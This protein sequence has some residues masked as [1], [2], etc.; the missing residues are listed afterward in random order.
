MKYKINRNV[1]R[2][3]MI[4][5]NNIVTEVNAGFLKLT[6]YSENE[7]INKTIVEVGRIL[8]I[9]SQINLQ[10]LECNGEFYIFH[11]SLQ[12][13][14][15]TIS[16]IVKFNEKILYF[17]KNIYFNIEEKFNFVEQIY[18]D[19]EPSILIRSVP[20]SILLKSNQNYLNMLKEP[21][22]SIENSIGK[23]HKEIITEYENSESQNPWDKLINNLKHC[24][25]EKICY[26]HY[27][28]GV[29][30]LNVSTMPIFVQGKLKY[31]IQVISDVTEK[32]QNSKAVEQ[33]NQELEAII[34]NVSDGLFVVDKNLNYHLYNSNSREFLYRVNSTKNNCDV[35]SRTKPNNFESS[36]LGKN[37]CPITRVL[38]GE[39]IR[40]YRFMCNSSGQIFHYNLGGSP[41]YDKNGNVEKAI[42]CTHDITER[43]KSEENLLI[44]TQYD[45]LRNIIENLEI[46]YLRC[47]YPEFKIIHLNNKAYYD[48]KKTNSTIVSLSSIE[49]RYVNDVSIINKDD[50]NIIMENQADKNHIIKKMVISGEEKYF[51]ILHHPLYGVNNQIIEIII[52]TIDITKEIKEKNEIE[53][54]IK[55]QEELF[56]NISHELKTPLN[57]IFSANQLMELYLRNNLIESNLETISRNN[58]M[59]KQNC[60]RLIKL[61]NN[62]V[63]LSKFESGFYKLHTS[64]RNIVR[65]VENI[66]K[67]VSD[68]INAVGLNVIFDSD[69][70]EKIIAIDVEKIERVILNLL[71]NAI[72][73]S[74][75]GNGIFVNVKDLGEFVEISVKDNG[76]GID[77]QHLPYIFDRFYQVDKSLTRDS[78]GSGIG[79]ALIKSIVEFHSGKISV[80]SEVDRG[81]TFKIKL[82]AIVAE[83][84]FI[85]NS[86]C[87]SDKIELINIEFSDIYQI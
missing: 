10:S 38:K 17:K 70:E 67:S 29:M 68:Y 72:K 57:V 65:V 82:P 42:I 76:I 48:L 45:L 50:L 21:Y 4:I 23:K 51:K 75:P 18:I 31:V 32:I 15:V 33:R 26:N 47:S 78:E 20:D 35:L 34:D 11:K 3:F 71:S 46:G 22:N 83:E 62:I 77:K 6:G 14:E 61:I 19:R 73:F 36:S 64:N 12:V 84:K 79:L 59:I 28:R 25:T 39:R 30:Y 9:D 66:V 2:P 44:K 41:I 40:E 13:I 24:Y 37:E 85:D 16:C 74:N 8:K 86:K 55:N 69:M 58:K 80:E 52:I 81:S 27:N 53:K 49:G 7:I 56:I 54:T 60:Y 1:I 43:L 63:D 87:M 5:K